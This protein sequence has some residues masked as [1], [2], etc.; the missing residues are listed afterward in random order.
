MSGLE[1]GNSNAATPYEAYL[2][3]GKDTYGKTIKTVIG[4]HR[5]MVVYITDDD[6]VA[7]NYQGLPERLRPIVVRFQ[8]LNGL[9]RST[10]GKKQLAKVASLLGPALYAG[11][12]SGENEDGIHHFDV[13]KTFI[14]AK[15]TQLSRLLYVLLSLLFGTV[16]IIATLI[17]VN[18]FQYPRNLQRLCPSVLLAEWRVLQY[19]LFSVQEAWKAIL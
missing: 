7:W 4:R 14:Y 8:Q 5:H 12:L 11:L 15:A 19:Q 6:A 18:T 2:T 1:G 16:V 17:F 13:P 9:A 3:G 10:L